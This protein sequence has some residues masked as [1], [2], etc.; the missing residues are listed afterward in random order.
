[1]ETQENKPELQQLREDLHIIKEKVDRLY[2]AFVGNDLTQDG[3]VVK[4]VSDLEEDV[5]LL[6]EHYDESSKK[7][8]KILF[9]LRIVWILVGGLGFELIKYI[10]DIIAKHST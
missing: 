3:G 10:L 4:R 2:L 7:D 8:F 5:A 1:M 6:K 9:Y